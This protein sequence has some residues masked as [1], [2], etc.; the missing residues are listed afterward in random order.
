[1]AAMASPQAVPVPLSR[2]TAT[3]AAEAFT[4]AK[5]NNADTETLRKIWENAS[6]ED[7]KTIV[8][9]YPGA[10]EEYGTGKGTGGRKRTRKS[11]RGG[12]KTKKAG[13]KGKKSSRSRRR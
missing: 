5:N 3:N 1:M 6:A 2:G 8:K 9:N 4:A 10:E 11:R 7:R 13:R 12:K